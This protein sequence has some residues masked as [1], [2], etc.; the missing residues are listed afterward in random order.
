LP[1]VINC[2]NA[3]VWRTVVRNIDASAFKFFFARGANANAPVVTHFVSSALG[4]TFAVT[5]V[6]RIL[7][8][9]F[10][11]ADTVVEF[12]GRALAFAIR[13]IA[14]SVTCFAVCTFWNA[15]PVTVFVRACKTVTINRATAQTRCR[16]KH[17]AVV[18]SWR[19]IRAFAIAR[20]GIAYFCRVRTRVCGALAI[21]RGW[22]LNCLSWGAVWRAGIRAV[23][24]AV[25]V[26]L[27]FGRITRSRAIA[28]ATV[29]I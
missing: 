8:T 10:A 29:R 11:S 1:A 27:R 18:A 16:V 7:R 19:R 3:T 17:F 22:V 4:N 23:T 13:R 2:F 21:A 9:A 28:T 14:R 25:K 6:M 15:L 20:I 24:R 26:L 12:V 5:K